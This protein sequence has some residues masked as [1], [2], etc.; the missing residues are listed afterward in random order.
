MGLLYTGFELTPII[1]NHLTYLEDNVALVSGELV[2]V[3]IRVVCE[4]EECGYAGEEVKLHLV[5]TNYA[6]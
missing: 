5:A 3:E 6:R 2:R 1:L 4:G